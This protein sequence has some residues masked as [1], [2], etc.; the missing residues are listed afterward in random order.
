MYTRVP[1]ALYGTRNDR[2]ARAVVLAESTRRGKS[3]PSFRG[4]EPRQGKTHATGSACVVTA[5]R[6]AIARIAPTWRFPHEE[7]RRLDGTD[8]EDFDFRGTSG[9]PPPA[10]SSY[11]IGNFPFLFSVDVKLNENLV[12]I[13]EITLKPSKSTRVTDHLVFVL[14]VFFVFFFLRGKTRLAFPESEFFHLPLEIR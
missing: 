3:T 8:K 5:G 2:S 13:F 10:C 11:H 1:R 6:I 7:I 14:L 4:D 12:G 9:P